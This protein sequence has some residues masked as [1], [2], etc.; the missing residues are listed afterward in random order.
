MR[1]EVAALTNSLP[2]DVPMDFI[3]DI[4]ERPPLKGYKFTGGCL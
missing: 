1:V 2:L 3:F 4:P